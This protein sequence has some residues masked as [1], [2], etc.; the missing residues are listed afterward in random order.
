MVQTDPLAQQEL[1][2]LMVR[3]VFP[4]RLVQQVLMESKDLRERLAH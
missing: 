4:D 1:T 3:Q 2:E